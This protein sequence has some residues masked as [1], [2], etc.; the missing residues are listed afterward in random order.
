MVQGKYLVNLSVLVIDNEEVQRDLL[1]AFVESRGGK[2]YVARNFSESVAYVE[3]VQFDVILCD[4]YLNGE[5]SGFD[6]IDRLKVIDR[7]VSVI[8]ITGYDIE[9]VIEESIKREAYAIV[10]KVYSLSALE[11]LMLQATRATKNNRRNRYVS[12]NMKA[13]IVRF[14]SEMK[15]TF[16]NILSS[17]TRALEA[18]DE[19]TKDHSEKVGEYAEK[20]CIEYSES[21]SFIE[22]VKVAGKLHDI[23][24]IG[25]RDD[26]LL[27]D[28]GLSDDEYEIV[29]QH[30]VVGYKIIKPIDSVGKISE[31]VLHHHERIDGSGYPHGLKKMGIPVGSRI[32]AVADAY[33]ALTSDRPYRGA[34]SSEY[35]IEELY[36]SQDHYDVE[37]IDILNKLVRGKR[38]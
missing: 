21:S 37:F 6:L 23:G 36:K 22:D 14:E 38:V 7:D 28:G 11:L 31:Y 30:P 17:L 16:L 8:L 9:S 10:Q 2:C 25:I 32:L 29:K 19:Y 24:K 34:N 15:K 35:A 3:G 1:R 12:S 18:K 27:K 33:S 13:R 20:M 5:G 26:I 4:I